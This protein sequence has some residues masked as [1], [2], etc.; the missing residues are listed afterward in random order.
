MRVEVGRYAGFCRGVKRAVDGTFAC[1][2]ELDEE[3]WTDGELIHNPQ[4]LRMLEQHGVHVLQASEDVSVLKDRVVV[5]RAHGVGRARLAELRSV[6]RE[7]RNLTCR[8]VARVQGL[9]RR[10]SRR[11]QSVVIFGKPDHPEVLGLLGHVSDGHVVSRPEEVAELPDL[12]RVFLVS[13]TTMSRPAFAAVADAVLRRFGDVEVVDTICDATELRQREVAELARRHSCVLVIGGATSSNTRR[14]Y[15]IA[16]VSS[17]AHLVTDLGD[18]SAIDL[19][20]VESVGITA[21]ASTPDWLIDAVV[22]EVQHHSSHPALQLVWNL[23]RFALYSNAMVAV[24]AFVLSFAVFD[25]LGLSFSPPI[26]LLAAC[27]YLAMSLLNGYTAARTLRIDEPRRWAF[28]QRWRWPFAV[29]FAGSAS[30]GALIAVALGPGVLMVTAF[31]TILGVAYNLSYLPSPIHSTSVLGVRTT[32]LLAV[33]SVVISVAVT[34]LLNGLPIV[35]HT[36][37]IVRDLSVATGTLLNLGFFFSLAYVF[38]VM[39]TRESLY[40][41]RTAQTDRIAGVSSLLNL[42]TRRQLITLLYALPALLAASMAVG[43]ALGA[44][45]PGKTRYFLA[46]GYTCLVVLLARN[47][48]VVTSRTAFELLVESNLYVAGLVA[49]L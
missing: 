46:V 33:K 1:A 42:L 49:L 8:D 18:V 35:R 48:A 31:S 47:R 37:G 7:V 25:L 41:L 26:A 40:E 29:L 17:R 2:R 34:V 20:G 44:Y 13:Q 15:E 6:A 28:M 5:V 19:D 10:A 22:E 3:V 39:L 36:P 21:G 16:S 32:D 43:V 38:V 45:P 30:A 11:S 4:T 9:V 27:Y 12:E 24:G 23:L 14:L